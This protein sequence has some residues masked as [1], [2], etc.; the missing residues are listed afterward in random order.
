MWIWGDCD[1]GD[2]YDDSD[3]H[4]GLYKKETVKT[5][6]RARRAAGSLKV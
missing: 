3:D 6:H 5:W 1:D 4:A 2:D